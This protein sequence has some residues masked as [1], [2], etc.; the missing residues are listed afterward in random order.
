MASLGLDILRSSHWWWLRTLRGLVHFLGGLRVAGGWATP[1]RH[2]VEISAEYLA[3]KNSNFS[4][5]LSSAFC[6]A[7]N[8]SQDRMASSST[9]FCVDLLRPMSTCISESPTP[10]VPADSSG[11]PT[12]TNLSVS[13]GPSAAQ[14]ASLSAPR[15]PPD[16][17]LPV[18]DGLVLSP[19]QSFLWFTI[20]V[21]WYAGTL[22]YG[23]GSYTSPPWWLSPNHKKGAISSSSPSIH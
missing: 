21:G 18:A 11:S 5:T 19:R 12:S 2:V 22:A 3:R 23:A 20:R 15:P 9:L 7:A 6:L 14:S 16:G 13:S 10:P 8:Y 17:F 4:R 1:C